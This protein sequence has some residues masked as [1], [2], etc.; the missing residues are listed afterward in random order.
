[1]R[2]RNALKCTINVLTFAMR[3]GV[4]KFDYIELRALYIANGIKKKYVFC[5]QIRMK[6]AEKTVIFCCLN[7]RQLSIWSNSIVE[8]LLQ[9]HN[10]FHLNCTQKK[11]VTIHTF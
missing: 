5:T 3:E 8:R 11:N 4:T 6:L 9:K 2:A 1:M 10:S 7:V